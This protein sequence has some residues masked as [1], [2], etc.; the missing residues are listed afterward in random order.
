MSILSAAASAATTQSDAMG[1]VQLA[2]AG[3]FL[4]WGLLTAHLL[5]VFRATSLIELSRPA[6]ATGLAGVFVLVAVTVFAW[7]GTQMVYF[8]TIRHRLPMKEGGGVDVSMFEPA[9]MAFLGTIPA[10]VGLAVMMIGD[11]LV[12]PTLPR[13]LGWTL[14]RV[15][16]GAWR[17][18][19][20]MVSVLPL[21]FGAAALL[22]MFYHVV[23]YEHPS[24]HEM[25]TVLGKTRD[26]VTKIV[27]VGGATLL[28]PV[29]EEFLFRG[30][31]Q[32]VLVRLFTPRPPR[33]PAQGFPV[34]QGIA[35][36]PEGTGAVAV[37]DVPPP[38]EP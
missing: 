29:F 22:Q 7:L 1:P 14:D 6:P 12:R 19:L 31:L 16:G 20:A 13:E 36:A 28:V 2:W 8:S 30:H 37:M 38:L 24:E 35:A 10:L 5:G 32:R 23:G 25:L 11:V 27:I 3:A 26:D 4:A 21:M 17:G 9:D 34:L 33:P 15:P 18:L